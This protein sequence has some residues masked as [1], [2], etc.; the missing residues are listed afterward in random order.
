MLSGIGAPSELKAADKS[1]IV[2]L[3]SVGKNMSDHALLINVFTTTSSNTWANYTNPTVLQ[4]QKFSWET[5]RQG[6]LSDPPANTVGWMRLPADD[7]VI[8]QHGDPSTGLNSA[9]WEFLVSVRPHPLS[10]KDRRRVLR[11]H[12]A[13]GRFCT[14]LARLINRV[15]KWARPYHLHRPALTD[16]PRHCRPG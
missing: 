12:W 5:T 16:K 15:T 6:P 10:A 13:S 2:A 4:Q 9:H 7:S 11:R 14:R 8:Q 3:P 1:T